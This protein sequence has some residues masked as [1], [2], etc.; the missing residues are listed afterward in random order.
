MRQ[1]PRGHQRASAQRG[2]T[3]RSGREKTQKRQ[4]W[5]RLRKERK[6]EEKKGRKRS[7]GSKEEGEIIER[8]EAERTGV[9]KAG[10]GRRGDETVRRWRPGQGRVAV[11]SG[12]S[13]SGD[14]TW[15]LDTGQPGPTIYH[16]PHPL[17]PLP[18]PRGS[19]QG[20][21]GQRPGGGTHCSPQAGIFHSRPLCKP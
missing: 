13:H 2:R 6:E 7:E 8:A 3:G 4:D 11:G 15:S 10:V 12:V 1:A 5:K 18:S 19:G 9:E 21:E 14:P 20:P 17:E 16:L